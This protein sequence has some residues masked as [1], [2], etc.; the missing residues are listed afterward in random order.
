MT[1]TRSG[2]LHGERGVEAG[3]AQAHATVS[4]A[5]APIFTP[6]AL[7][8]RVPSF[9]AGYPPELFSEKLHFSIELMHRYTLELAS[10]LLRSLGVIAN[11]DSWCTPDDLCR[12]LSFD[13]KF[14][15]LLRWLMEA[16]VEL[17]DL[18]R[19]P[20]QYGMY[21]ISGSTRPRSTALRERAL[22]VD[23]ANAATLDL[24]EHAAATYPLLARGEKTAEQLLFE[25]QNIALWLAYF[26]NDNPTYAVN[27]WMGALAAAQRMA[28]RS[29]FSILEV[30]AGA[31]SGAEI[32]LEVL[33]ARGLATR[34]ER[35]VVTEPSTFFLRRAQRNLTRRYPHLPL[36]FGALDINKPWQAQSPSEAGF[37]LVYGINVMHVAHD[38]A[39]S[40]GQ[41]R[42]SIAADGWLVMG[43]C[44][45]R[46]KPIFPEFIFQMLESFGTVRTDARFRPA[47]GFLPPH[48]WR[49][50]LAHA[51]FHV[52]QIEPDVE[53]I[54]ELCPNFLSGAVCGQKKGPGFEG[55]TNRTSWSD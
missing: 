36:E 53:R 54:S 12:I 37:E 16:A 49:R 35:Y 52:Q 24:L 42:D 5:S 11:L 14:C 25:P 32:L 19:E 44:L 27:N 23:P 3:K 18:T 15:P 55:S 17:G 6:A 26:R 22:A 20:H 41:A 31:G 38:L 51:G 30:G 43:E 7:D 13:P 45:S 4:T 50:S 47:P 48:Y 9:L 40:L 39:Y 34:I 2:T 1:V 46:Y 28:S 10:G 29:R 8:P 21:K 33:S